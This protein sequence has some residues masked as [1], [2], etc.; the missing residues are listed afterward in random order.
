VNK[1]NSNHPSCDDDSHPAH[2]FYGTAILL[3]ILLATASV[4]GWILPMIGNVESMR[5]RIESTE[6]RGINPAAI[7]YTDVFDSRSVSRP[8]PGIS[9]P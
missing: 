2:G 6:R 9:Q 8:N 7:Y 3:A 4:W 5:F 1:F